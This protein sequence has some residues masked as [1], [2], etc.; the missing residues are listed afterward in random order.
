M[1]HFAAFD[2]GSVYDNDN[3]WRPTLK[4]FYIKLRCL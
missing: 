3:P 4:K 2:G 1:M